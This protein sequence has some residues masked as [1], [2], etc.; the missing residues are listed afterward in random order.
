MLPQTKPGG[1]FR[2]APMASASPSEAPEEQK[3]P[4]PLF[5]STMHTAPS[6]SSLPSPDK[7]SCRC[8]PKESCEV[9]GAHPLKNPQCKLA[10]SPQKN[11]LTLVPTLVPTLMPTSHPCLPS[12][13]APGLAHD[14]ARRTSVRPTM[15]QCVPALKVSSSC[16]IS[17]TD[18]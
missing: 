14:D 10:P 3:F 18:I 7:S 12:E 2:F 1:Q 6:L 9:D 8:P 17:S 15:G 11:L 13:T 4:P 5:F 16:C